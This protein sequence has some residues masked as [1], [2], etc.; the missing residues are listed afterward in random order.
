MKQE[1]DFLGYVQFDHHVWLNELIFSNKEV[2]LYE[3]RLLELME[4]V[5]DESTLDEL[6][7][8]YDSFSQKNEEIEELILMIRKHVVNN[9]RL[10]RSN[11]SIKSMID[12]THATTRKEMQKFR[13]D[14][15]Q[16]KQRFSRFAIIQ[17]GLK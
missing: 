13:K 9:T 10:V 5:E 4:K 1:L 16:L 17:D 2:K 14:Y 7:D 12:S 3:A 11:G 15:A 8:L 6:S